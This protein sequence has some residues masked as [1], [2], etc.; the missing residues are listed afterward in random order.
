MVRS[1]RTH[2]QR[3]ILAAAHNSPHAGPI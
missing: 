2:G 3:K 1:G